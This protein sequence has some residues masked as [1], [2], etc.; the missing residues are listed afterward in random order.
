[1]VC[2]NHVCRSRAKYSFPKLC[3]GCI[4][5]IAKSRI[6]TKVKNGIQT[7]V[8]NHIC[9]VGIGVGPYPPT[10]ACEVHAKIEIY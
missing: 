1:M 3:P 10:H 2:G 6:Q 9:Y 5:Q 8:Q 7:T 4:Q